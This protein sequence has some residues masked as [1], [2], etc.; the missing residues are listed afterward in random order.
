MRKPEEISDE[1]YSRMAER[2][3]ATGLL[4]GFDKAAAS[5]DR[6]GMIAFL[7]RVAIS[8]KD[9]SWTADVILANPSQYGF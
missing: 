9:A 7:R 3:F 2:L 5:R 1:G 6:L 8:E 4:Y